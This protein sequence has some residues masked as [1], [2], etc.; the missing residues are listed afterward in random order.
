[1]PTVTG[2]QYLHSIYLVASQAEVTSYFR[3]RIIIRSYT[4]ARQVANRRA[5]RMTDVL[6]TLSGARPAATGKHN[7]PA[8][9]TTTA[10][11]A[12][13]KKLDATVTKLLFSFSAL[14]AE[15][16]AG[17]SSASASLA[18]ALAASK[19]A[20]LS[21]A[22]AETL[23]S[24]V[25]KVI[26]CKNVT[27]RSLTLKELSA[28]FA[29]KEK[30]KAEMCDA[31]V[32]AAPRKPKVSVAEAAARAHAAT[33]PS[34]V[35][36]N[37]GFRK[38]PSL[39]A[40]TDDEI[41]QQLNVK[42]SDTGPPPPPAAPAAPA[43]EA[44]PETAGEAKEDD[45][46]AKLPGIYERQLQW[47]KKAA[48]RRERLKAEKETKEREA[49]RPPEGSKKLS[50]KWAHVQSVM[51]TQRLAAEESWRQD[52]NA[53]MAEEREL[54]REAE[55]KAREEVAARAQLQQ[56]RD[57][58]EKARQEALE[59]IDKMEG[60]M[61]ATQAKYEEARQAQQ[62]LAAQH[63]E[64][65]EIRDAFGDKGLEDWPMFPGRKVFRVLDSDC[66]DGRVSQE[67]RVKDAESGDRG[68]S[69]LMGRLAHVKTPEAQCVLFDAKHFTDL[70]A[71]RWWQQNGPR[72]E[73]AKERIQRERQRAQSARPLLQR[74]P[75]ESHEAAAAPTWMP[76]EAL[77]KFPGLK[78]K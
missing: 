15:Q 73:Q 42:K 25:E 19:R 64:A 20:E 55:R 27:L 17:K 70:Q 22:I 1:M 23:A 67:Y 65:L 32:Q 58:A 47:A 51:K 35:A 62:V 10:I 24:S 6:P 26:K 38:V 11:K 69:L 48:E 54:R 56:E 57:A 12:M 63:K 75:R 59:K 21:N 16:E 60:R 68:V 40:L 44:A 39:P 53:E 33:S 43:A 34:A 78:R 36:F 37:S 49:E 7:A 30:P 9:E 74:E 14:D 52:M 4:N 18:N 76:D 46:K 66:F 50:S 2:T 28:K 31:G 41:L 3:S 45:G 13:C 61:A 5:H 72:F 8:D 71:A 77:E 29:V